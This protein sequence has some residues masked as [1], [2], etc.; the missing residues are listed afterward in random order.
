MRYKGKSVIVTG[1][2]T[3]IGRAT[4]IAFARE[5][6]AVTIGDF[7]DKAAETVAAIAAE[8][9]TAYFQRCDVS[10]ADEVAALVEAAVAREGKLD[11]AFNNAGIYPAEQSFADFDEAAFDRTIA[12]NLKGVF[13]CVQAEIRA[14]LKTGGGAI[15]NTASV[16]GV[17]ANPNMGPYV[18]SKHGVVGLTKAAAIEYVRSGIRVNTICPGLVRT[19]MTTAWFDSQEFLDAFY[20]SS[21]IG[22]GAE[23]E[24]MAGMVLHLCSSEAS[25][26]NGA[27]IV[28]DGGQ[29][30]I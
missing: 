30:A 23:P 16:G 8:G 1:A 28:M 26:T 20:A 14:M 2:A 9:G 11:A 18:A 12:V 25:F 3:G 19:A 13:L 7:N 27:V 4:A 24:E 10:K 15:V 21:P 5:G 22:R 17:I 29:T 6:A